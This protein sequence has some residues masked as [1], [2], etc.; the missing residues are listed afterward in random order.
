MLWFRKRPAM[1]TNLTL[2]AFLGSCAVFPSRG[3]RRTGVASVAGGIGRLGIAGVIGG[4]VPGILLRVM[5]RWTRFVDFSARFVVGFGAFMMGGAFDIRRRSCNDGISGVIPTLC[6]ALGATL[7]W[8]CVG[9]RS[10]G[11]RCKSSS[12]RIHAWHGLVRKAGPSCSF[13]ASDNLDLNKVSTRRCFS[14][15]MFLSVD[16]TSLVNSCIWSY[17]D[18]NGTWQ[19]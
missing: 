3:D 13:V 15:V 14:A 2:G 1:G 6:S 8:S 4:T 19:C 9:T 10:W 18:M 16:T 12:G 7:C 17:V 5:R 11:I